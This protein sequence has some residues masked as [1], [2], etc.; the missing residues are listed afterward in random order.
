MIVGGNDVDINY[1][2]GNDDNI[3]YVGGFSFVDRW[4][5]S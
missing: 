4:S 3:N 1:A 2:G 5:V